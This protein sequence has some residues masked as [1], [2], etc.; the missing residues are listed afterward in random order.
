MGALDACLCMLQAGKGCWGKAVLGHGGMGIKAPGVMCCMQVWAYTFEY[1]EDTVAAP[2]TVPTPSLFQ[3]ALGLRRHPSW[4]VYFAYCYPYC[5]Y[6][7]QKDL[8]AL[9]VAARCPEGG[10]GAVWCMGGT[11]AMG[12]TMR[13]RHQ[14]GP[15]C[16]PPAFHTLHPAAPLWYPA[17]R[18]GAQ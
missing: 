13:G 17:G 15:S 6:N 9:E 4:Q 3:R 1:A 12:G 14:L 5:Y 18:S 11:I 16:M 2:A 7:L 8:L 10:A